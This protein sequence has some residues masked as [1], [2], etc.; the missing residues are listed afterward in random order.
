[1]QSHRTLRE[2]SS[3]RRDRLIREQQSLEGLELQRL[4]QF[5]EALKEG[6]INIPC[7]LS[8]PLI[9]VCD[10]QVGGRESIARIKHMGS[11]EMSDGLIR[12][13]RQTVEPAKIHVIPYIVFL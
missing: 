9:K 7:A 11:L 5:A 3:L 6:L 8:H 13:A 10:R 1:M 4:R 12:A 2:S